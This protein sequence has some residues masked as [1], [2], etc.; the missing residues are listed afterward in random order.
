MVLANLVVDG[1][2]PLLATL[3]R[4]LSIWRRRRL[5]D[6]KSSSKRNVIA[7]AGAVRDLKAP[8]LRLAPAIQARKLTDRLGGFFFAPLR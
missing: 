8:K 7:V 3:A 6:S 4:A 2:D 5:L 1:D